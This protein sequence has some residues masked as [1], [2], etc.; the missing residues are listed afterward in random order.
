MGV[1]KMLWNGKGKSGL[2]KNGRGSGE[3]G[4]D[5]ESSA[6]SQEVLKAVF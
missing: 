6:V 4:L 3:E 5:R 1:G 2:G